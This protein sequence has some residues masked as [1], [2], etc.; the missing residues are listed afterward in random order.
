MSKIPEKIIGFRCYQDGEVLLGVVDAQLPEPELM[1]ETV[2]GAGIAG[3]YES[4]VMG[5]FKSMTTTIK[6]RTVTAA[7][8]R[9]AK[10]KAV[11]LELRGSIQVH[12]G[13]SGKLTPMPMRVIVKGL[14]KKSGLGKLEVGKPMDAEHVFETTYLKVEL[15]GKEE[16][17]IDKLN[18]IHKVNGE[19][20]L[21]EVRTQ[22]GM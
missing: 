3:E 4:P 7:A 9:L 10:S 20:Q 15:N 8:L 17:E 6:F 1:T 16:L 18:Y 2:S 12:D 11:H 22:L 21:A 13:G 19:D 5:H 14:P